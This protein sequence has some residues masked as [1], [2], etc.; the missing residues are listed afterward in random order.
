MIRGASGNPD[1]PVVTNEDLTGSF[2][3][4][5]FNLDWAY[6]TFT[7]GKSFGM[8]PGAARISLGK[9]GN[10]IFLVSELVFDDDLSPEGAFET[11]QLL[12]QPH[13][14]LDQIK[15]HALQWTFNE[16]SNKEGGWMFGGQV[17]PILHLGPGERHE[18]LPL[19]V[20]PVL[21]VK[22]FFGSLAVRR[23]YTAR[24]QGA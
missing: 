2:N 19:D 11:F 6:L 15:V 23:P 22:S 24:A 17:N 4:K 21:L 8:R 1:D 5:H 18:A 12:G 14:S 20:A 13:G 7:P 16:V 10:P 9:F 3:R